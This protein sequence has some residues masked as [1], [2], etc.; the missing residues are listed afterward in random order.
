M[1]VKNFYLHVTLQARNKKISSFM[2]RLNF[3]CFLNLK[4]YHLKSVKKC[5]I[6][7]KR[8]KK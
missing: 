4:I 1:K 6:R 8:I 3:F 5:F 7:Y 2:V